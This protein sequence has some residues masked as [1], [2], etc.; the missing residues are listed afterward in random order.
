M[1]GLVQVSSKPY[2]KSTGGK[3][4]ESQDEKHEIAV[5]ETTVNEEAGIEQEREEPSTK[6]P[7]DGKVEKP[8]NQDQKSD[9]E[10]GQNLDEGET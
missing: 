6:T 10:K 8:D 5:S 2:T 9:E 7:D 1:Q 4:T 3:A